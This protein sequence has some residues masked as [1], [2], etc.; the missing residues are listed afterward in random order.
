MST[1]HKEG[2]IKARKLTDNALVEII[3]RIKL[4]IKAV[5]PALFHKVKP[6]LFEF[7]YILIQFIFI[8]AA[9]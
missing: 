6:I 2:N 1:S 9:T 8:S 7:M 5:S 3:Y 4:R